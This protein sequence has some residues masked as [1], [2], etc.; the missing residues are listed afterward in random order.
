MARL[1]RL[2]FAALVLLFLFFVKEAQTQAS[3]RILG[4]YQSQGPHYSNVIGSFTSTS[5]LVSVD[6]FGFASLASDDI[7]TNVFAG[8]SVDVLP[9]AVGVS[10]L[11]TRG[12]NVF[13]IANGAF[14]QQTTD[15]TRN[16]IVPDSVFDLKCTYDSE[17][18]CIY[19]LMNGKLYTYGTSP[20]WVTCGIASGSEIDFGDLVQT[21]D[22]S[23]KASAF[24]VPSTQ[25]LHV[26][27]S[28][29]DIANPNS[30]MEQI[31]AVD[32]DYIAV[33]NRFIL[34]LQQSFGVKVFGNI[35]DGP[36]S[37]DNNPNME[38]NLPHG[39]N[40]YIAIAA[41]A[42][43]G[44]LLTGTVY[45]LYAFG[46]ASSDFGHGIN[47]GEPTAL[48]GAETFHFF[49]DSE[50]AIGIVTL[51]TALGPGKSY[52][53]GG[54][55]PVGFYCPNA[56]VKVPCPDGTWSAQGS[57]AVT[58]CTSA[59][60]EGSYCRNGVSLDCGPGQQVNLITLVCDNCLST[61]YSDGTECKTIQ[62]GY[63]GINPTSSSFGAQQICEV[64]NACSGGVKVS[65]GGSQYADSTG[66]SSCLSC[67]DG[68]YAHD[69]A[70]TENGAVNT[71]CS[72]CLAG[73]K[74]VAG[75][76][77]ACTGN[78]YQENTGASV[79]STCPGGKYT[80]ND[81]SGDPNTECNDCGKGYACPAD[82]SRSPCTSDYYCPTANEVTM[83][84]C[85][86]G[87]YT[88]SVDAA[89]PGLN[90]VCIV[91]E[92]GY[93]CPGGDASTK[94]TC[95]L[96]QY[97]PG[98]TSSCQ[99][100]SPGD[101]PNKG[102]GSFASNIQC[103]TCPFGYGCDGTAA[104]LCDG[105]KYFPY[106]S[107]GQVSCQTCSPGYRTTFPDGEVFNNDCVPC[108]AGTACDGSRVSV[109]CSGKEYSEDFAGV[110]EECDPGHFT[111]QGKATVG[112]QLCTI[113]P[114]GSECPDG[115][116]KNKCI[117][118]TYALGEGT[119]TCD[120]CTSTK[121]VTEEVLGEGFTH[122]NDCP[123]G[124]ACP[125]GK[126]YY[127]C[128]GL[129][130]A[131]S[132]AK[133]ECDSCPPGSYTVYDS[134]AGGNVQCVSCPVGK[135]CNGATQF[136]CEGKFYAK[137][138]GKS[139]CD[140]CGVGYYIVS[141]NGDGNTDCLVCPPGY[142][143]TDGINKTPCT[144]NQYSISTFSTTCV[145]C[146]AGKYAHS[147]KGESGNDACFDCPPGYQCPSGVL[148]A[149]TGPNYS[150]TI[151]LQVCLTCA[152][153]TYA[154]NNGSPTKGGVTVGNDFCEA[155]P[156]G[157][158]CS[159]G[160]RTSCNGNQY[161]IDPSSVSCETCNSGSY[162]TS[163]ANGN[164]ACDLCEPGYK[165]NGETRTK[166]ENGSEYQDDPGAS[167]CKSCP[168]GTTPNTLR[169]DCD[170]C[171]V[172]YICDGASKTAC[173]GKLYTDSTRQSECALCPAGMK[174]TGPDFTRNT[175]CVPC[176]N[177]FYCDGENEFTCPAGFY[178]VANDDG[179]FLCSE[180]PAGHYCSGD[181]TKQKCTDDGYAP[182]TGFETCMTCPSGSY[183]YE[184]VDG[185]GKTACAFCP[186]G[187]QCNGAERTSC[188][189]DT[190]AAFIG[191]S[192]CADCPAGSYTSNPTG[193]GNS[194]CTKCP[195]GKSCDGEVQTPCSGSSYAPVTGLSTCMTCAAG[196]FTSNPTGQGNSVC[197][198]CPVGSS[199]N[200]EVASECVEEFF[201]SVMGKALC[202]TC[203]SGSYTTNSGSGNDLCTECEVGY[204]CDGENK[205]AC[206]ADKFADEA[207]LS[208]CLTCPADSYLIFDGTLQIGCEICPAG[209]Y[210][211]GGVKIP[212]TGK[213]YSNSDGATS[214]TNCPAG[215]YTTKSDEELG[216]TD[217]LICPEGSACDGE[218]KISCTGDQYSTGE[219]NA[220][221]STC[222]PGNYVDTNDEGESIL[223]TPCPIGKSCN[224]TAQFD[225]VGDAYSN[226]LSFVTCGVCPP[227]SHVVTDNGL[228]VDCI[229]CEE[230]TSC[231]DGIEI[232]SC[233]GDQFAD[234]SGMDACETCPPGSYV[235]A[236]ANGNNQCT[237][238]PIGSFCDG[239]VK[240]ICEGNLFADELGL[241]ECNVCP[242]GSTTTEE[243]EGEGNAH[244]TVCTGD[245]YCDGDVDLVCP[246]GSFAS[247]A[248]E[249]AVGNSLCTVCPIGSSCD[250]AVATLCTGVFY[251]NTTG[252]AD[253][254][255]CASGY[256]VSKNE[257]IDGNST[258]GNIDCSP[259][260]QGWY[261][262]DGI[263]RSACPTGEFTGYEGADSSSFCSAEFCPDDYDC[264]GGILVY[265]PKRA[266]AL[267]IVF[268]VLGGVL[269]LAIAAVVVGGV[270]LLVYL[271]RPTAAAATAAATA[272]T[273]ELSKI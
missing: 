214:C 202:D 165:C 59:L 263:E 8:L 125:N 111:S 119:V 13:F 241:A 266:Q 258:T 269:L 222:A 239:E 46:A 164:N 159:G 105:N 48:I 171:E 47:H 153:G 73:H 58:H 204:A 55:C 257:T 250:G 226:T 205:V 101:Y 235:T 143:C 118:N 175:A 99:N 49:A 88:D 27:T 169:T 220:D 108:Y 168:A 184:E 262:V 185:A 110:C 107:D 138:P 194:V 135:Y 209:E 2:F 253:C 146:P 26:C 122:C 197:T 270:V 229:P 80:N 21:F 228:N 50:T 72:A 261:C 210:C 182:S 254:L 231:P 25:K 144:G 37:C 83:T 192:T 104:V 130:Y 52:K 91:C 124:N 44:F 36:S 156:S 102:G 82:G 238:C 15:T 232:V 166:C 249:T 117:D 157:S 17:I 66:L 195:I 14:Y 188:V 158:Q 170:E 178:T 57:S 32:V 23:Q 20:N 89:S 67:G 87:F 113:C 268:I 1:P 273:P 176:E 123:V 109:T 155:C 172:G 40:P 106:Q 237:E 199:C 161:Q 149:C 193:N 212:C 93:I 198:P 69:G 267:S 63:Y 187:Y 216:Y 148:E 236:N 200:G 126:Y 177:E 81:I 173:T 151:N 96:T 246:A 207:G 213:S 206:T 203:P 264:I 129:F 242:I 6:G 97:A 76:K 140:E 145:T 160:V 38:Q 4:N 100:C 217:C 127:A 128:T 211:S 162:T 189:A 84:L 163:G 60:C 221:C 256:F 152:D 233:T 61:E 240:T 137:T 62:P 208:M 227:G 251:A 183:A 133:D 265:A 65:C 150:D 95:P 18:A 147:T 98:G 30:L 114:K 225:C 131:S 196:G 35:C 243:T 167:V 31:D 24:I 223:C 29:G 234:A 70:G 79:C 10:T 260:P 255:Q 230:G 244:C 248:N 134:S 11:V 39:E 71:V 78:E 215:S 90:D 51:D 259:C 77:T 54:D 174:T 115:E 86:P 103:S 56:G 41:V 271:K 5:T 141:A 139:S 68:Y 201:A 219:N 34:M 224:G 3:L 12:Q 121:Y 43:V 19:Q 272:A 42:N 120:T 154:V 190:Y 53:D 112:N 45:K 116:V 64:G 186:I 92:P 22:V 245:H 74:C 136:K 9:P 218:I 191:H 247:P 28:D 94:D 132:P 142:T 252:L 179:N 181:G 180:C 85:Y 75:V 7:L 16:T 33:G